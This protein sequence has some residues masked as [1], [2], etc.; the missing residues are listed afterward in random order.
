MRPQ[1]RSA[2]L[3]VKRNTLLLWAFYDRPGP[4]ATQ[5]NNGLEG[6]FSDI[7]TKFQEHSGISKEHRKKLSTNILHG[8]TDPW[9][10]DKKEVPTNSSGT[11]RG[12]NS[13]CPNY[14]SYFCPKGPEKFFIPRS[15]RG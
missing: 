12:E 15:P 13:S 14:A 2:Y 6:I 8:T 10:P 11:R 1:L 4:G 7:K 5:T 3:S 9:N